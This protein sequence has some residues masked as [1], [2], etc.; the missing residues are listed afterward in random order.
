MGRRVARVGI[1]NLVITFLVAIYA[2]ACL[3]PFYYFLIYSVSSQV[4][5]ARGI[6]LLP[7]G[8]TLSSFESISRQSNIRDVQSLGYKDIVAWYNMIPDEAVAKLGNQRS[9]RRGAV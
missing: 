5:A 9:I 6:Y 1:S 7:R 4:E 3:Y 8:F 2:F